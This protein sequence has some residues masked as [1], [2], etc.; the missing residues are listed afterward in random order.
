MM[1]AAYAP[2]QAF[3]YH[4]VIRASTMAI[5]Y[6]AVGTDLQALKGEIDAIVGD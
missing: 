2:Q 4:V 1:L 6:E 3:P 5:A